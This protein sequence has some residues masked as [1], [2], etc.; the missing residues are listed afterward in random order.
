MD[1]PDVIVGVD[2]DAD[3]HALIPVIGQR[4]RERRVHFEARDHD[5]VAL[6]LRGSLLLEDSLPE[7]QCKQQGGER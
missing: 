5:L 3:G 2:A 6:V 1:D 7:A 4:L